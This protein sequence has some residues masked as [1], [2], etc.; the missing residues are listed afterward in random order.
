MIL[1]NCGWHVTTSSKS[2]KCVG[3]CSVHNLKK[4]GSVTVLST[5]HIKPTATAGYLQRNNRHFYNSE[6]IKKKLDSLHLY[7]VL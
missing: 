2:A 3:V 5:Q 7:F 4:L 1:C 6:V